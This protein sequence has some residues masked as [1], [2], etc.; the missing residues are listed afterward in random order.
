MSKRNG[1]SPL[2]ETV[3]KMLSA[4][5]DGTELRQ[6]ESDFLTSSSKMGLGNSPFVN[7]LLRL[8]KDGRVDAKNAL[9]LLTDSASMQRLFELT[10]ATQIG[11]RGGW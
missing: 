9:S 1:T 3:E 2:A 5:S 10:V 7:S 4:N 8:V 6:F 11:Q